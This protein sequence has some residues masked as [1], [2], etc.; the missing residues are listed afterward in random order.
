MYP[1]ESL[2]LKVD[3]DLNS[4]QTFIVEPRV[5][6]DEYWPRPQEVTAVGK[7]IKIVNHSEYPIS[8][9]KNSLIQVR[10]TIEVDPIETQS[11]IPEEQ[12]LTSAKP[13]KYTCDI[14]SISVDQGNQFSK[15][16]V[17]TAKDIIKK[18]SKV[19]GNDIP[20]Y[21]GAMGTVSCPLGVVVSTCTQT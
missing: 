2:S 14:E 10:Q 12:G 19:F 11:T 16:G 5:E 17:A 13:L 8:L 4:N 1:H 7:T 3:E 20:G 21:N 6:N 15:E 18:H 9:K